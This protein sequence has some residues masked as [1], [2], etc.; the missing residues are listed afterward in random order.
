MLFGVET[1]FLVVGLSGSGGILVPKKMLVKQTSRLLE[2]IETNN[3]EVL[4]DIHTKPTG[5][6][7]LTS[8]TSL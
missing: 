8:V 4:S 7:I 3:P 6:H 5:E 2:A 1:D